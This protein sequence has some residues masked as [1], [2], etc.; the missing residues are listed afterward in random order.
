MRFYFLL[1]VNELSYF[2]IVLAQGLESHGHEVASNFNYWKTDV[3]YLFAKSN[4]RAGDIVIS[5]T[6]TNKDKSWRALDRLVNFTDGHFTILIDVA[7]GLYTPSF[8]VRE[9]RITKIFKQKNNNWKYP[10]N[11]P[12]S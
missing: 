10:A 4:I 2:S 8:D 11:V 3:G 6:D 5:E 12:G 9:R 1:D 7:D